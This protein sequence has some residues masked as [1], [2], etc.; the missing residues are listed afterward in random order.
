MDKKTNNYMS[1]VIQNECLQI[2]CLHI[3]CQVS[4]CIRNNRFYS[5]MADECTDS[6]NKE[7]FTVCIR[8]VDNDL[9][10]HENF[11]EKYEVPGIDPNCLTSTLKDVLLRMSLKLAD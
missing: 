6:A 11:S 2:M 1:P 5:I 8:L 4:K 10:D 9:V 3:L 7:Q